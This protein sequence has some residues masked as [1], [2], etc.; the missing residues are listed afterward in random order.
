[1]K[2]NIFIMM[3]GIII[4]TTMTVCALNFS[5]TDIEFI[6][7]DESWK[8]NDLNSALNGLYTD[9]KTT[10][11]ELEKSIETKDTSITSLN[12]Q[13][14]SL[15]SQINNLN[16]QISTLN[17]ET[18]NLEDKLSS[19]ST[20][21]KT[22]SFTSSTSTQTFDLG[23]QPSYIS[24]NTKYNTS[25]GGGGILAIYNKDYSETYAVRGIKQSSGVISIGDVAYGSYYTINS[26]GFTWNISSNTVS[27][28]TVYCI[29]LN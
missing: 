3:L 12:N 27:G 4:G 13:I 8:I 10:I 11:P 23:F 22:L 17:D 21:V 1:M 16:N 20:D 24:C 7:E 28:S 25:A 18:S 5:A 9:S 26:N 2:N 15:N 29:A 14:S 6:P 19:I